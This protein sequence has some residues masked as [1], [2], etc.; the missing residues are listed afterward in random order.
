MK[1]FITS[2]PESERTRLDSSLDPVLSGVARGLARLFPPVQN[3]R[4]PRDGSTIATASGS[5]SA[6]GRQRGHG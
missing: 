1:P 6:A 3:V 5:D 2:Q 4:P